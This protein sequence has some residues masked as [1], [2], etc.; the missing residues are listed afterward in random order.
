MAGP[1]RILR[2]IPAQQ[3]TICLHEIRADGYERYSVVRYANRRMRDGAGAARGAV[4]NAAW[5]AGLPLGAAVF[6]FGGMGR[7]SA[8]KELF[9]RR[10]LKR[11]SESGSAFSDA[12]LQ[13]PIDACRQARSLRTRLRALPVCSRAAG[14]K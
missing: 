8:E 1:K 13:A 3:P 6:G 9:N 2:S 7:C 14:G 4:V 11:V 5:K 12:C 10:A